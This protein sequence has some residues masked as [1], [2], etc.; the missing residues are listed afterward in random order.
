ME[1]LGFLKSFRAKKKK[2]SLD[3]MTDPSRNF[4]LTIK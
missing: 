1:N 2:R 4:A 3:N